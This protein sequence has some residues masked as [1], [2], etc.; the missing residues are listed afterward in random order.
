MSNTSK[1]TPNAAENSV[2]AAAAA[3]ALVAAMAGVAA[4]TTAAAAA[5]CRF[6]NE[7]SEAEA[8]AVAARRRERDLA[9]WR[10]RDAGPIA[11]ASSAYVSL[12][13]TVRDAGAIRSTAE[14]LGFR[15]AAVPALKVGDVGYTLVYRGNDRLAIA[16]TRDGVVLQVHRAHVGTAQ[17]IVRQHSIDRVADYLRRRNMAASV[18]RLSNDEVEIRAQEPRGG[19]GDDARAVVTARVGADGAVDLDVDRCLGRRCEEYV[20]GIAE[21]VGGKIQEVKRKDAWYA[22]TGQ[23]ADAR[24]RSGY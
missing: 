18:T 3:A 17:T 7:E 15:V 8:A 11:T 23:R 9:S 24:Q 13:L 21:A 2:A 6:L 10:V 1:V 12:P 22:E 19:D 20:N 5:L 16:E 14:R 4:G